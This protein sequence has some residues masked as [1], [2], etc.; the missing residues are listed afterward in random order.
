[1][2][3][4]TERCNDYAAEVA[5]NPETRTPVEVTGGA[6]ECS[7]ELVEIWRDN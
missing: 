2:S 7:C 1:M 4:T 5:Q 3:V 6:G